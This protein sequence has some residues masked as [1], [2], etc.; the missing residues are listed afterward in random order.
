MHY[1]EPTVNRHIQSNGQDKSSSSIALAG[2][3]E[4][5]RQGKKDAITYRQ[6]LSAN[7]ASVSSNAS[8]CKES[9]DSE[10]SDDLIPTNPSLISMI[11]YLLF[12]PAVFAGPAVRFVDYLAFVRDIRRQS[13]LQLHGISYSTFLK[14]QLKT[15]LARLATSIF[16]ISVYFV[17]T[18]WI[19]APSYFISPA[20]TSLSLIRKIAWLMLNGI[21]S[22][23][24]YYTVWTMSEA[25]LILSGISF[26]GVVPVNPKL[27]SINNSKLVLVTCRH[28]HLG[29]GGKDCQEDCSLLKG[30][31]SDETSTRSHSPEN[32]RISWDRVKAIHIS[33]VEFATNL[34][35]YIASW[36][37]M[38]AKWLHRYVY[39]G[40]AGAKP[41]AER[42]NSKNRNGD[43]TAPTNSKKISSGGSGLTATLLTNLVSAFWHGF[44]PGYYFCFSALAFASFTFRLLHRRFGSVLAGW[45][46]QSQAVGWLLKASGILLVHV[47]T[48]SMC[49]PFLLLSLDATMTFLRATKFFMYWMLL[50]LFTLSKVPKTKWL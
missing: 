21:I 46:A 2:A 47:L 3:S 40:I 7:D 49:M 26:N 41:T 15:G 5:V 29:G 42:D 50:G 31:E 13:V 23:S 16:F 27:S 14:S 43:S 36:N 6:R 18:T 38:T 34:R 35:D 48:S 19:V 4:T 8:S 10:C 32:V 44:H 45:C 33:G 30:P 20:F 17:G 24:R 25:S 11:G 39:L 28:G 37:I 22:R 1:R 9:I 12:F